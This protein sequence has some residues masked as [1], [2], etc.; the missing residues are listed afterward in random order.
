MVRECSNG[1]NLHEYS[2]DEHP[3]PPTLGYLA[4][5]VALVFVLCF[6]CTD[7]AAYQCDTRAY[8]LNFDNHRSVLVPT[9]STPITDTTPTLRLT[10]IKNL[11]KTGSASLLWS[12]GRLSAA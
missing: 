10:T 2:T 12:H 7:D 5:A 3:L 11:G 6:V 8:D 4:Y 1:A 9:D